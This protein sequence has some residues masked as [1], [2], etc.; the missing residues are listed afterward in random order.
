MVYE[1]DDIMPYRFVSLLK[2]TGD[3]PTL[4]VEDENGVRYVQKLLD[5]VQ[6]KIYRELETLS[7][8]GI[9]KSR[10]ISFDELAL[11]DFMDSMRQELTESSSALLA[12]EYIEGSDVD[13]LL[14]SGYVFD[15][16][17]FRSMVTQLCKTLSAVHK[18]GIVHRDIKPANIIRSVN[19]RYYLVD[20]G[21]ARQTENSSTQT[22]VVATLGYASPEQLEGR[23]ATAR[24]D[25]YALGRLMK[26][27]VPKGRAYQRICRKA[28]MD[29]P[30][31]RYRNVKRLSRAVRKAAR[32]PALKAFLRT[33]YALAAA[34][35]M[36]VV[37]SVYISRNYTVYTAQNQYDEQ[38]MDK[39]DIQAERERLKSEI[40]SGH[41]GFANFLKLA[42]LEELEG[43]YDAAADTIIGYI[44]DYYDIRLLT[45]Q[46]PIYIEL[47]DLKPKMSVDKQI[48]TD[49]FLSGMN[50]IGKLIDAGE[51]DLAEKNLDEITTA[52]CRLL[53]QS[54]PNY[55]IYDHYFELYTRRRGNG[56]ME[57]AAQKLIE[58]NEE[59]GGKKWSSD[60]MYAQKAKSIMEEVSPETRNKLN[61]ICG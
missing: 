35:V 54:K 32:A 19:G 55:I 43:N 38:F 31:Q 10:I 49:E 25:I 44:K 8:P 1:S 5:D 18:A 22:A 34:F 27:T 60:N 48:E 4:L 33:M 2:H 3:C 20:F 24:S 15:R 53:Q 39:T 57:K 52:P 46:S 36:L 7:V 47:A 56:D 45:E 50:Y 17:E 29:E 14:K 28:T 41:D 23:R 42:D 12:E 21:I 13:K 51:Y 16:R 59:A 58:L 26:Q 6:A 40:E 11:P 37:W 9:P 30:K 61:E